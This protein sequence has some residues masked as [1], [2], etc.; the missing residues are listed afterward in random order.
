MSAVPVEAQIAAVEREIKMRE[1]VY[2]RRVADH[3]MTQ[4]KA[5]EELAAMRAVLET[6]RA[7]KK[8]LFA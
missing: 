5:E 3:K 6:L 2:P 8:D 7:S 1:Y 4:R